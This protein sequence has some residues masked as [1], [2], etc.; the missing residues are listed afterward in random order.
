[1]DEA[2]VE[3]LVEQIGNM[4]EML[5]YYMASLLETQQKLIERQEKDLSRYEG[6][7]E[8]IYGKAI[9]KQK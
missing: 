9:E 2:S 4:S 3:Q 1:M 7:E 8:K 5:D 6:L